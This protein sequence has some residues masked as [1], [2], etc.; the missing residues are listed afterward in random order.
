MKKIIAILLALLLAAL[1]T[2][3]KQDSEIINN[4][5][6]TGIESTQYDTTVTV[7]ENETATDN[8]Q[9]TEESMDGSEFTNDNEVT[10]K[11]EWD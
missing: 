11:A 10:Y 2:S 3:C 1:L 7:D 4:S 8:T 5:E 6:S 9:F